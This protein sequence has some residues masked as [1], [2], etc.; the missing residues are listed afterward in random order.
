M[1]YGTPLAAS[2]AALLLLLVSG[3]SRVD[4]ATRAQNLSPP[5]LAF[6][7]QWGV[8]GD[9]PGQL[10]DPEG[11]TTDFLGNVYITDAGSRFVH[12]FSPTGTPLLS[13]QDD[14][15]KE[16]QSIAVDSYG[17]IYVTDPSRSS[18]FIFFP[19]DEHEHHHELRLRTRT[20][21][22][23][24][25]SVAVD[26]DGIIYVL[27]QSAAKVFT[28]SPRFRLE[29]SWAPSAANSVDTKSDAAT[30]P[31]H[32]GG[33]NNLYIA[34]LS[35]NRIL[36]FSTD[37]HFLAGLAPPNTQADPKISDE[38]AVSRSYIF[39][40]DANGSMLHVWT[41]DGAPKLD[42]DLADNLGR[43]H[44]LPPFL[45]VSPR[46]EL[47]VLDGPGSRVLRYRINF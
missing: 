24:S 32:L 23:N 5:P 34:D 17:A 29:R 1:A 36:R 26:D 15:L 43:T 42:V 47:F 10:D 13:F 46:R 3:C 18:V 2:A 16:P 11:I 35:G 12:K 40:M 45:A 8:K 20:S 9:G 44:R 31:L 39:L 22:E 6:Q 33:D 25:L 4:S 21:A 28:F 7:G 41:P 14:A 27:D 37:G 38:F 19:D 30:G